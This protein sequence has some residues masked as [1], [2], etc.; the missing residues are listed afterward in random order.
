MKKGLD[1]LKEKS[2]Q[3][4]TGHMKTIPNVLP[5]ILVFHKAV[6]DALTYQEFFTIQE[7]D[8]ARSLLKRGMERID[9][10]V[11]GDLSWRKETGPVARAYRSKIDDSLQPYGAV[12]PPTY[13]PNSGEKYRLDIW[14]HG[15]G[16][17]LSEVNFLDERSKSR[18]EFTPENTIVLHPYGRFCN[19]NKFAGEIDLLEAIEA[20]KKNYKIDDDRI[21]VRGFSMGGAACWQFAVHYADHWFAANPGAGF[22][23]TA[24]FLKVFQ[25]EDVKPTW[26]E[27]ALW[28]MY[29][30]TDL[31]VNLAQCPTV[32]YSGE[33]D[34]QKQAADVMAEALAREGIELTHLIGPKTPHR[35]H[36]Q[37]KLEVAA[38]LDSLTIKGRERF[39]KSVHFVTYT[40]KYNTMNWVTIDAL[41]E[42][43]KKA[44][45]DAQLM[46]G[47][48]VDVKTENVTKLT[49]AFPAGFSPFSVTESVGIR[50]DGQMMSLPKAGSD[51][52]WS[53]TLEHGSNGLWS[54]APSKAGGL[55]KSHDLQGPIDDAFM[56]SF[57]MIK[58]TG[59]SSHAKFQTW[60]ESEMPHAIE[61]W[62]RQFR[63]EARVKD[64][65]SVEA[66][67]IADFES[68][69]LGRPREQRHPQEDRR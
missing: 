1:A 60:V 10:V 35:Y 48:S 47:A 19:A 27:Q 14:C 54:Q 40:L 66:Q 12:V 31:A 11:S 64:D 26:Y 52:S 33:I 63:G 50:I 59:K 15:R 18:G 62:R 8:K 34:S 38:K 25:K 3:I 2:R 32:A 4:T 45:V 23:E 36:P 24:Q 53:V 5:D 65:T 43:W 46:P 16:E 68:H 21:A 56:D 29:D 22:A 39:P 44:R 20:V 67:D 6:S 42:H 69:P 49:L 28:H 55:R 7:V 37:S 17:M 57:V 41:E 13:N 30:C 58:P 61:H 51:R 9:Q